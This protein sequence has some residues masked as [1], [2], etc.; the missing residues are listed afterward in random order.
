MVK[1]WPTLASEEFAD[2]C[3]Q[4]EANASSGLEGTHWL[5]LRWDE[6]RALHIKQPCQVE[7][8]RNRDDEDETNEE[9][10][11]MEFEDASTVSRPATASTAMVDFSII[12]SPTYQ[13]PVLWFTFA[14]LPKAGPQGIDA[15]YHYLVPPASK[16]QVKDLGVMG[17]ISIAVR[18]PRVERSAVT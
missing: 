4:L 11:L 16:A 15:V 2:A 12:M 1:A 13:V 17:G 7:E 10:E 14:G 6:A 18:T 3:G 5:S 9:R 8:Q